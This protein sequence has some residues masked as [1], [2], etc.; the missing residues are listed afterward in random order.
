M[1]LEVQRYLASIMGRAA[2]D[3]KLKTLIATGKDTP[4][5]I[6]AANAVIDAKLG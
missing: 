1:Y 3:D 4:E 2:K 5:N 6:Q